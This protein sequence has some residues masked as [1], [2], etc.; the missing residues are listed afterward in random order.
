MPLTQ[1]PLRYPGGKSKLFPFVKSLVQSNDLNHCHYIEP[2]AGGAGLPISLLVKEVV[3][4]VHINDL[5]PFIFSFWKS[6]VSDPDELCGRIE[7]A[8]V[9]MD[10]WH[11]QKAILHDSEN[12]Y[13]LSDRAFATLFLNRTN[14]SGI[15]DGGVVGG[16]GQTGEYKIDARFNKATLIKKIQ[17]IAAYRSRITVTQLDAIELL[18]G[19]PSDPQLFVNLDPPYIA[20]GKNLYLN[21]Y[22]ELDHFTVRDFLREADF[23]WMLTYDDHEL[24]RALYNDFNCFKYSLNYSAQKRQTATELMVLSPGLVFPRNSPIKLAI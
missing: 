12:E 14:R 22:G 9:S 15:L 16:K 10:E 24:A 20:Q 3:R 6:V 11:R 19:L 21:H 23:P 1:T 17:K 7:D 18:R 8:D 2:Y 5:N 13:S 4:S